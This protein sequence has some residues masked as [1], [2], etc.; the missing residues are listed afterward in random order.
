[1]EQAQAIQ[2]LLSPLGSVY[3]Q[4]A[5]WGAVVLSAAFD[6]RETLK[7]LFD[8]AVARFKR[9]KPAGK[10]S[11]D[12]EA[13]RTTLVGIRHKASEHPDVSKRNSYLAL[14]DQMDAAVKELWA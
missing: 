2:T 1:M 11:A 6:K 12:C 5:I 8:S 3:A 14:C 7:G 9:A 4:A 10:T 13:R